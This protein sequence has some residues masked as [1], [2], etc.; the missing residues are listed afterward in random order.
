MRGLDDVNELREREGERERVGEEG[1]E[2]GNIGGGS[3]QF[4]E[5]GEGNPSIHP[6]EDPRFRPVIYV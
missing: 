5:G 3:T 2:G 6:K 4:G 1:G